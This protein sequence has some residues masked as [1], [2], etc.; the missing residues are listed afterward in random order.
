MLEDDPN[1]FMQMED[2]L[3][4]KGKWKTTSIFKQKE[5]YLNLLRKWKTTSI[6]R[7]MKMTSV[8]KEMEDDLNFFI[9]HLHLQNDFFVVVFDVCLFKSVFDCLFK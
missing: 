6:S 2:D 5:D 3:D 1:F 4:F 9:Y 8:L 7:Q